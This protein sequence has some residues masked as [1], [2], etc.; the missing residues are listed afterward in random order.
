MPIKNSKIINKI[1]SFLDSIHFPILDISLWGLLEIYI[2][3][4]FRNNIMKQS[5]S[6]SWSFF[7]SLFPFLLFLLSIMPYLPHYSEVYDYIFKVLIPRVLPEHM[8]GE[9]IGYIEESF[10]PKIKEISSFTIVLVL[11]FATNG[12]YSM[13]SG[14]N[15]N[16]SIQR[17]MLKEYAISFFTTVAFTLSIILFILG[18]YYGEI[19][20]KLLMPEYQKFWW[21]SHLTQ[22]IGYFSFPLFYGVALTLFY[23]VGNVEIKK[24]N[25]ALP[26]AIFT[27]V[28]F[29]L[30]TSIFAFYV[31]E[32]ASYNVLY[33]SIGSII[34]LMI[35]V[36]VNVSLLL[37][38]NE[39]NLVIKSIHTKKQD[40]A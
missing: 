25:Q 35:W 9:V 38:G 39:L 4:L 17:G 15:E 11:F 40:K 8:Q 21:A 12:T 3:G 20:L 5:A 32:F 16:A 26:G 1:K 19:V 30:T 36:N 2:G 33:G 37:F 13:I 18:I 6:I 29:V 24:L 31:S 23:W 22:I 10:M 14:F 28:L 34:L 27:T 7:F